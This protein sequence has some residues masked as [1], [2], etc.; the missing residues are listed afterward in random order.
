MERR[1][2]EMKIKREN[3]H[4]YA[5]YY[6]QSC[7]FQREREGERGKSKYYHIRCIYWEMPK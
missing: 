6:F 2:N 1:R 7:I 3:F 5:V 4:I